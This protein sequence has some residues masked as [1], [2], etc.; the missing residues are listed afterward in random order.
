MGTGAIAVSHAEAL[1]QI[2]EARVAVV[3]DRDRSKAEAFARRFGIAAACA[4]LDE[5][6][7]RERPDAAHVL[8]PPHLHAE[9]AAPLLEAG[10]HVL[11]EKPMV[12]TTEDGR[13]LLESA[14]RGGARLGVNHNFTFVPLFRRLLEDVDAG[15]IGR[16]QH[17]VSFQNN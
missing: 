4:S 15:R 12:L 5:L 14:R 13:R 10:V 8:V 2:A 17:V 3:C 11:L 1:A 9:V 7:A 16:V 6:L